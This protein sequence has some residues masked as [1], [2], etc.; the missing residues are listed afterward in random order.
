MTGHTG[1]KGGWL[2]LW[3]QN[4]SVDL[5]GYS[6]EPPTKVNLFQDARVG[7]GMRSVAG[8]TRDASL[9]EK[10]LPEFRP[11][12]VFHLAAQPSVRKS[13]KDPLS[14]YSTNVMG[15]ANVLNAARHIDSL[16]VIVVITSVRFTVLVPPLRRMSS[17][18]ELSGASIPILRARAR[19]SFTWVPSMAVMTSPASIPA[20]AA[21]LP[22]WG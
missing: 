10:T 8:D 22:A 4:Q 19:E 21:G 14:T 6:L 2:S 18:M 16:R 3:L 5:C 7:E 9:L 13:Y 11:E 20:L 12:I 15:T 1:F 17:L